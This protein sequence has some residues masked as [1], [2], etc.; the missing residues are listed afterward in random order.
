MESEKGLVVLIIAHAKTIRSIPRLK[1]KN[2]SSI[3]PSIE[4]HRKHFIMTEMPTKL[5]EDCV[6]SGDIILFG[7]LICVCL[8]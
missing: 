3:V 4:N 2:F 1:T 7:V 6:F 8:V 5:L